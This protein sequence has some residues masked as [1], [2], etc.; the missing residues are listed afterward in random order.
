[1]KLVKV[2]GAMALLGVITTSCG[3]KKTA[4]TAETA[5]TTTVAVDSAAVVET[6]NIVGVAAGNADFSTLVT[7]VKAAG[8]V[9]TLS[10]EGPFTV[11]APNNAA[12]DKLPA[13]TV[14]G[15]LKPESLDKLKAVLTYHVVSGKFDAAAVTEAINK[16]NGKFTVTTVQGGKIELSLKDGKVILTDANGATSTV[17]LA[18]VAASNGV[19]HAIDSVVMPK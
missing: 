14:D 15:L 3:E 2:I 5:D 4:E 10:S 1:M 11:F 12:F 16:N 8:L 6:P 18:D 13:G 17:V 9:E 7:A 19:I